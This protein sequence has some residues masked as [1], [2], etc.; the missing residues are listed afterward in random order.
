MVVNNH[1]CQTGSKNCRMN[2]PHGYSNNLP[3]WRIVGFGRKKRSEA[4]KRQKKYLVI[5]FYIPA[6]FSDLFIFRRIL[7]IRSFFNLQQCNRFPLMFVCGSCPD[8]LSQRF[9]AFNPVP[10]IFRHVSLFF[11]K[12][13]AI[14]MPVFR[15]LRLRCAKCVPSTVLL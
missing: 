8:C 10:T 15:P 1:L 14:D 5:W 2:E 13:Q 12:R 7:S 3:C 9:C 4:T 11:P 6:K